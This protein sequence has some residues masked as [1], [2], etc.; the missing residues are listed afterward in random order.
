[1]TEYGAPWDGI[2]V[3]DATLAPYSA[4]EWARIWKMM[5]GNG[6]AYPNHGVFLGSGD[7]TNAPLQVTQ[8]AVAS[9]NVQVQVGAALV[10]GRFYENTAANTIAVT[11]NSS[12]NARIDTMVLRAD[13]VAQ[14]VRLVIKVGTPAVSPARPTLQQDTSIWEEPLADIAVANGFVTISNSNITPRQR[15]FFTQGAYWQPYAFP[16]NYYP[17]STGQSF[18]LTVAQTLLVPMDVRGNMYLTG[19]TVDQQG[20]GSG[21]NYTFGWDLYVN[22]L[23]DRNTAENTL[24]RVAQSLADFSGTGSGQP[25]SGALNPVTLTPGIYWL[26]LQNRGA[27]SWV[28]STVDTR[29]MSINQA[30][31]KTTSNPNG[32]TLDAVSGGWIQIASNPH[33][34]L[35][36]IVFGTKSW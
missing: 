11:A 28:V 24:R 30:Q 34:A 6:S 32:A 5:F 12:G 25:T 9:S 4:A 16:L 29:L 22:D 31:Y 33:V 10:N 27:A 26:A 2:T 13:Y 7:G 17:I 36:G 15:Y 8:T 18:S 20:N 14:T 21:G 35:R 19:I 23:N 3:G 1:M